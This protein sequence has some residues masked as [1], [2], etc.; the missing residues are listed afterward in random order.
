MSAPVLI[1]DYD[2][3]WPLEF[4]A[5]RRG[6]LAAVDGG[7]ST[8]IHIGSTAVPG[9]CAK[10][11][12]DIM[13]GVPGLREAEALLPP[14]SERGYDDV[15]KIDD[16]DEWFYCL[17]KAPEKPSDTMRY[18]HLHLMREDSHD[19]NRHVNFRDYLRL[20]PETAAIYCTLKRRLAERFR[21]QREVYTE[22]KTRFIREIEAKALTDSGKG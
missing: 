22:S 9:L 13:A 6:I 14:L 12:V 20:H 3:D 1:V 2:P 7:I 4:E 19:W 11:I 10:P 17:G 15:T 8:V 16:S 5:E 21:D 18:F